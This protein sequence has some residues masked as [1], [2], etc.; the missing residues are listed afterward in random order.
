[1]RSFYSGPV[2][3]NATNREN[4]VRT[5]KV[6]LRAVVVDDD[7]PRTK[8]AGKVSLDAYGIGLEGCLPG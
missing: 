8:V 5:I 3:G 4:K 2:G 6:K 7:I 1:M